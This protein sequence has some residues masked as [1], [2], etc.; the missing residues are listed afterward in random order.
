MI[1]GC[2]RLREVQK[3]GRRFEVTRLYETQSYGI[4]IHSPFDSCRSGTVRYEM[5]EQL[6][7]RDA[8]HRFAGRSFFGLNAINFFQAEMVGVIMPILGVLLKEH[9]WR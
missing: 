2:L 4:G 5:R 8:V 1:R 9:G 3:A 7:K 6:M